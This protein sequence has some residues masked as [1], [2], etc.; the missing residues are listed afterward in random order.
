M[1]IQELR[2]NR[3][4]LYEQTKNFLDSKRDENGQVP[5]SAMEQYDKMF[6]D[7]QN[8]SHQIDAMERQAKLDAEMSASAGAPPFMPVGDKASTPSKD[9]RPTATDRYKDA[10]WASIRGKALT[11]E[12][13]NALSVGVNPDGGYLVPDE[14]DKNLVQA[15][16]ENNIFRTLA[17]VIR[18]QSGSHLIPVANDT[19]TAMWLDEGQAIQ[20]TMTQ[21]SQVQLG[22]NKLGTAI[23][24]SNELLNDSVF[25]IPSYIAERFGRVMGRTEEDSFINGT[26][27]KQPTGILHA[28]AGGVRSVTAASES[29]ITLDEVIELKYKLKAPYRKDAKWLCNEDIVYQLRTIKDRNDRY[30]W[31]DSLK[32]GE[33]SMLLGN[34]VETSAYMPTVAAGEDVLAFGDFKYYWI[35]DRQSRTFKRLNELYAMNDQVAFL[36]TQRVDGKLILP[37][38]VQILKMAGTKT[39]G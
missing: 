28:T 21:F 10:F 38:A 36:T 26:G 32:E 25:D 39:S 29:S 6:E 16:E 11:L 27:V 9:A 1:T 19:M 12:V 31:A 8:M 13:Q 33:P 30:I 18:T 5:K 15:L 17:H 3:A 35:A 20:E 34:P 37:E 2:Q 14:F 4:G 7:I 23:R 22:A 24:V